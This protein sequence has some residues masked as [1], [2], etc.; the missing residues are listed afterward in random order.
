MR[1]IILDN[2]IEKMRSDESIFF[3]TADMG[4]N[5]VERIQS[6][7][8]KRFL[9]VGIAEQNAIGVAAGLAN[10]GYR[11]WVYSI[12]NFLVHRCFEQLRNDAALHK[13]PITLL[14]TSTG[15]DNAPLGPT[16]HIIDDW[17]LVAGMPG[18]TVFSPSTVEYA[19]TIVD[20]VCEANG[21]NYVRVAKGSPSIAHS[22]SDVFFTG[23]ESRA[24]FLVISYGGVGARLAQNGDL[25]GQ[26]ALAIVNRLSPIPPALESALAEEPDF[27]VVV[28][29]Q[30]ARTGL[31]SALALFIATSG[32]RTRLL[33]VAPDCFDLVVGESAEEYD[34]RYALDP[35]SVLKRIQAITTEDAQMPHRSNRC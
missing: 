21:V 28:E 31:A 35:D 27:V 7:F 33:S 24:K 29:D 11:P 15:F 16:H 8:P 9:N 32:V 4:I 6:E 22:D 5:L 10:L 3:I 13:Y 26:C 17:G 1:G 23:Q 30:M 25:L 19:S 18:T 12:S 20:R 2:L 14:G 34:R